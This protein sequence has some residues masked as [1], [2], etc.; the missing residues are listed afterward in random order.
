MSEKRFSPEFQGTL[1]LFSALMGLTLAF[2]EK[3]G[4]EARVKACRRGS[5]T[6][7]EALQILDELVKV[8]FRISVLRYIAVCLMN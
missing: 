7:R 3:Y 8:G 6:N 5:I 4:D 1:Q 2:K